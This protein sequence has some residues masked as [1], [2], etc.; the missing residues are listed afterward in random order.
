MIPRRVQI[1]WCRDHVERGVFC[2]DDKP[3]GLS[4]FPDGTIL[5]GA[6]SAEVVAQNM[7]AQE[8]QE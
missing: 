6:P 5:L 8:S 3:K 1:L 2:H 7:S 4:L